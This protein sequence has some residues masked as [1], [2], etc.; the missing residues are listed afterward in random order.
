MKRTKTFT[1][2]RFL[3]WGDRIT[4]AAVFLSMSV[5]SILATLKS[6]SAGGNPL[7]I[8]G[9]PLGIVLLAT[10]SHMGGHTKCFLEYRR[11]GKTCHAE[12]FSWSHN[13]RGKTFPRNT[14]VQ[15]INDELKIP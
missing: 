14:I 8:I 4:L 1:R 7:P 10:V 12:L 3:Y 13:E 15:A 5:I 11:S 2:N 6:T 9:I